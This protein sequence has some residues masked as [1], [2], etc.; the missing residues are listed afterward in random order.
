MPKALDHA[1]DAIL[2]AT[3]RLLEKDGYESLNVRTI[4]AESGMGT[5]TVYNYFQAKDEIV[6]A[7]MLE[8]WRLALSAMD[9]GLD[10]ELSAGKEPD[11]QACL[12][13]VFQPLRNF[14][15]SYRGI[16]EILANAPAQDKSPSVRCYDNEQFM[17]E[18]KERVGRFLPGTIEAETERAFALDFVTRSLSGY[19]R[20]KDCDFPR[21]GRIL[22]RAIGL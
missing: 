19:A 1:R 5:G 4:A 12:G 18:L 9:A 22:T 10:A 6:I 17:R 16:W 14:I 7:L 21:L 2:L 15:Q 3:R 11:M 20:S 13:A 8:D